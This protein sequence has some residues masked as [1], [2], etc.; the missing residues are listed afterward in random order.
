M[1]DDCK[2]TIDAART[3]SESFDLDQV[4]IFGRDLDTW[5]VHQATY[6]KTDIDAGMA[7]VDGEKISAMLRAMPTSLEDAIAAASIVRPGDI[8]EENTVKNRKGN[9]GVHRTH[10]CIHHGC[11][12]NDD[13]CPVEKFRIPQD[14]IC[15]TCAEYGFT[16]QDVRDTYET[17]NGLKQNDNTKA[18]VKSFCRLLVETD[19]HMDMRRSEIKSLSDV[20]GVSQEYIS[21]S[22]I[23]ELAR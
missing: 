7:A 22:F 2:L 5:M 21:V 20:L 23:E 6:G 12:Y 15:E 1:S 4:I 17:C 3:I 9:D 13:D 16:L 14:Y 18:L 11:K 10:C 19:K 8:K